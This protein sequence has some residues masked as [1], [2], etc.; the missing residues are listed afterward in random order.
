MCLA[1]L[2]CWDGATLRLSLNVQV[3]LFIILCFVFAWVY[4]T[5]DI[6]HDDACNRCYLLVQEHRHTLHTIHF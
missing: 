5:Y 3:V 1:L 6:C 2:F 4:H